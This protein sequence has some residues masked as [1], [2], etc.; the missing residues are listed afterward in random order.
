MKAVVM[1]LF[2]YFIDVFVNR[3]RVFFYVRLADV[4]GRCSEKKVP[5]VIVTLVGERIPRVSSG[6]KHVTIFILFYFNSANQIS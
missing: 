1:T 5:S 6:G 4:V 2:N 3:K